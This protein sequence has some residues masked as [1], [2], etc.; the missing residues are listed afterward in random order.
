MTV[1][2][3]WL[4]AILGGAAGL[5]VLLLTNAAGLGGAI[6][7]AAA[8]SAVCISILDRK[9]A[10]L[11]TA[12]HELAES[13]EQ[14][15]AAHNTLAPQRERMRMRIEHEGNLAERTAT[16]NAAHQRE[17]F[18]VRRE[19]YEQGAID[20][21]TGRISWPEAPDDASVISLNSRRHT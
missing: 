21:I 11:Q 16:L 19:W 4:A 15:E 12:V 2:Q 20:M 10:E 13:R 8:A 7:G 17:I 18:Q 1:N 6:I 5:A 9:T 14:Y 3:Q